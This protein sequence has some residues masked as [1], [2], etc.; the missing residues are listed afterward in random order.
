MKRLKKGS[1]LCNICINHLHTVCKPVPPCWR[2]IIKYL[3]CVCS[4]CQTEGWGVKHNGSSGVWR[5]LNKIHS[6]TYDTDGLSARIKKYHKCLCDKG[7]EFLCDLSCSFSS[8]CWKQIPPPLSSSVS[9]TWWD[10]QAA[11]CV[12][13]PP[14]FLP[15]LLLHLLLLL[16]FSS[17]LHF[18]PPPPSS[19]HGNCKTRW[20]RERGRGGCKEEKQFVLCLLDP[21]REGDEEHSG[22]T[23][24]NRRQA[25]I[26][27]CQIGPGRVATRRRDSRKTH[28]RRNLCAKQQKS[29]G[30]FVGHCF[31]NFNKM[32][33]DEVEVQ[34]GGLT[35]CYVCGQ[36]KTGHLIGCICIHSR[37]LAILHIF[38][39]A[40][41][42]NYSTGSRPG[43]FERTSQI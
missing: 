43:D 19:A 14:Q 41:G 35:L 25:N 24:V 1:A 11:E 22:Q 12:L 33:L 10:R 7:G 20:D 32:N 15:L 29:Q 6:L 27:R 13:R 42:E 5:F 9:K 8:L 40:A 26:P 30:Q 37:C 34:S 38:Y 3:P 21:I 36:K 2:I 17:L 18:C 4:V 31:G 23:E 16:L 39:A 28:K